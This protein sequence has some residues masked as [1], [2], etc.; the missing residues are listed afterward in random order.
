MASRREKIFNGKSLDSVADVMAGC[1]PNSA[2]DQMAR[3]EFLLRQAK[4]QEDAA[5]ATR[6]TACY[7]KKYTKYMFLSVIV[8]TVSVLMNFILAIL[9]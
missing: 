7:T 5:E 8:L 2:N 4:F 6:K 3:A 1:E 9:N